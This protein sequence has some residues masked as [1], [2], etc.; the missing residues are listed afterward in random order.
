VADALERLHAGQLELRAADVAHHLIEAGPAAERDRTARFL[1]L[2]GDQALTAAAFEEAVRAF[3]GALGQLGERLTPERAAVLERLGRALHGLGHF[4]EALRSWSDAAA[5]YS[6]LNEP[7]AVGAVCA[8]MALTLAWSGR[9]EEAIEVAGRGLAA[10]GD[11][12]GRARSDLLSVSGLA[13]SIS[14]NFEMADDLTRRAV[15]DAEILDDPRAL[16]TAL[17]VREVHHWGWGQP[18]DTV[19]VGMRAVDAMR[20]GGGS[21]DRADTLARVQ[22]GL[23]WMG[24]LAEAE[25]AGAEALSLAHTLGSRGALLTTRWASWAVESSRADLATLDRLAREDLRFAEENRFP[26]AAYA[27]IYVGLAAFWRG[28]WVMAADSFEEC[29]RL[30]IPSMAVGG[31]W[32]FRILLH[33]YQGDTQRALAMYVQGKET[34]PRLGAPRT[35]GR[36]AMLLTVSEA[37]ALAG[38]RKEASALHPMVLEAMRAG[39]VLRVFDS[40]LLNSVAGL[41]AAAGGQW[42]P[43]EEHLRRA[44][45]QA[46]DMPHRIER[47]ETRR[48]YAWML[49]ERDGDGDRALAATLLHEALDGYRA[50]GMPRHEAMAEAL[51]AS[52]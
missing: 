22:F 18:D 7:Q 35:F 29:A 48:L 2:A 39:N 26:W 45:R 38:E 5:A 21:V 17:Y 36:L 8:D 42:E 24:R 47:A 49:V 16:A 43:A 44:C 9:L 14:C 6:E 40:R 27:H 25:A 50:I 34:L 20:H 23:L 3:Q 10:V 41:T 32:G 1:I 19:A 30:E 28:D 13:H 15:A 12:V 51:L 33:V 11:A 46:D 52:V 4:D 31:A 37:L